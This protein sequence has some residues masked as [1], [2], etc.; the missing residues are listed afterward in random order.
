MSTA[1]IRL[2]VMPAKYRRV[3]IPPARTTPTAMMATTPQ[4]TVVPLTPVV[5]AGTRTW[6]VTR[7]STMVLATV[8]P[9][10]TVAPVTAVANGHGCVAM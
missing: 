10:Y 1:R 4:A 8:I 6:S 7:P 2:P 9:A 5:N 3:M